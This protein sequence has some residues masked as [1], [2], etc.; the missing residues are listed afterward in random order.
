MCP[1]YQM[2]TRFAFSYVQ[3][4][5]QHY[6]QRTVGETPLQKMWTIPVA[7]AARKL[8]CYRES[9]PWVV[10]KKKWDTKEDK[11]KL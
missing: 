6:K 2:L 9:T 3:P 7:N 8:S 4:I 10:S 11:G 5:T 1:N